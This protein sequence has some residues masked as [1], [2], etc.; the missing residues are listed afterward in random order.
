MEFNDG[1][2]T[3]IRLMTYREEV[4]TRQRVELRP[5]SKAEARKKVLELAGPSLVEMALVTFVNMADMIMVGRLGPSAIAAVGLTNQPVFFAMAAF[6]ALNVGTTA[7]IARA[8]GAGEGDVANEAMRQSLMLVIIMGFA[9][10]VLGFVFARNLLSFMGAE[11]DVLPLGVSYMKIIASGCV[12]MVVSMSL[13][14]ALRGAGDTVSPMKA[15]M[16]ANITNVIGNYLLIYGK[17]GFPKLGVP[18]A[19]LATT[20]ARIIAFTL[21]LRVVVIGNS[22]LHL[23]GPFKFNL[24]LLKRIIHVGMPSALEQI[25]LRGGQLTYVRIVA[26]FGTTVIAAHQIGINITSLSFMPGMAFAIAATTLVGQ[27]LGAGMPEVAEDWARETRR[28]GTIVSCCMA[29]VFIL[30]GKYIAMLYTDDPEV[31]ARTAVVLRIL[32]F[33]QPAQSTQFI[34]AGGLRGAG[35]TRWPLYST[36]IGVWGFRVAVGYLLAVVMGME[37][38]GAWLGM[39]VDQLARSVIIALRFKS[40]KWKLSEV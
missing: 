26:S 1:K 14:A 32:G 6:I 2:S 18:G 4:E 22:H 21:L 31:I 37:L 23:T 28:M 30:F 8:I 35:D 17:F 13:T 10:S 3:V 34:L 15:N 9:V 7:V 25:I 38:V 29:L 19:A 16:V 12:F 40:G 20:I 5:R 24:P 33:V 27:G 39:A 11:A 36:A